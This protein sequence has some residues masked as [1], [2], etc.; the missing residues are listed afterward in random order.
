M[1]RC[2]TG[3]PG[4]KHERFADVVDR[5]AAPN[6]YLLFCLLW[7][8]DFIVRRCAAIYTAG[9]LFG[10]K[11]KSILRRKENEACVLRI[12]KMFKSLLKFFVV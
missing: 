1:C 2:T 4:H 12:I 11:V 5:L 9:L 8:E 7:D 3:A 6:L 10:S